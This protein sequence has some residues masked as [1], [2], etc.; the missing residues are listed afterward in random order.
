MPQYPIRMVPGREKM[1]WIYI[2]VAFLGGILV[3]VLAVY[4]IGKQYTKVTRAIEELG[5][6][7]PI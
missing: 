1:D 3:A 7:P 4:V 5:K 6:K 2:V